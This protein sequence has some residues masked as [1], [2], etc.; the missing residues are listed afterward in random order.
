MGTGMDGSWLATSSG[1]MWSIENPREEQVRLRDIAAGLSR[2]CR[3]AG[4]ISEEAEFYSV[5][6]H[7]LIM[8]SWAHQAGLVRVRSDA[9]LYLLHDGS[10]AFF[11]DMTTPMKALIP[12][13]RRLEDRAQGVIFRAFG[14][15]DARVAALKA[16]VKR[17]D[18]RVRIDEREVMILE[19]A[20]TA[21]REALW[22]LDPGVE[23][24]GV[25]PRL[26]SPS[27]A[28][29]AYLSAFAW[30]LE[31]LPDDI[32][33]TPAIRDARDDLAGR[34]ILPDLPDFS[35]ALERSCENVFSPC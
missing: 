14:L 30:A 32:G 6:E 11:G 31:A 34:G 20:L 28:R 10:E 19:P 24:L 5:A 3:Y 9:L 29:R 25:R 17:V 21:G 16:E 13:F 26:L 23:P 8:T 7:S 12:D 22:R 27:E 15:S 4:Q 18:T 33:E 35:N 1:G 2:A